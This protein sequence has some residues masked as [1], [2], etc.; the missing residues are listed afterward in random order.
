MNAQENIKE[1]I[2]SKCVKQKKERDLLPQ[3]TRKFGVTNGITQQYIHKLKSEG[4]LCVPKKN[5][6]RTIDM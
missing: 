2:L 3:V 1:Y 5:T 6:L 4:L